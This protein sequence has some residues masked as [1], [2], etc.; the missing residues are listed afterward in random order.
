MQFM[1]V[2]G[3]NMTDSIQRERFIVDVDYV[4][5]EKNMDYQQLGI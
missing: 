5:L 1:E 3:I 4:S 2:I